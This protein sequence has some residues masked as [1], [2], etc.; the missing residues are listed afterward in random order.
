VIALPLPHS[1]DIKLLYWFYLHTLLHFLISL[2]R[3][4]TR[5]YFFLI[6]SFSFWFVCVLIFY[7]DTLR[8]YIASTT[9][10]YR[11][12]AS[13]KLFNII[14]RTHWIFHNSF[15]LRFFFFSALWSWMMMRREK[16]L[17]WSRKLSALH[18]H[19]ISLHPQLSSLCYFHYIEITICYFWG[20]LRWEIGNDNFCIKIVFLQ[21]L[22]R[23]CAVNL[24]W[25]G[26]FWGIVRKLGDTNF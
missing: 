3:D 11:N 16:S 24:I 8:S 25:N 7:T 20:G 18:Y 15:R 23:I 13:L 6:S 19:Y 2:S 12:V 17:S 9:C 4:R 5:S 10:R 14:P 21:E 26:K 1:I 22:E